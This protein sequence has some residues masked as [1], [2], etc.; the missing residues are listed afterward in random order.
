MGDEKAVSDAAAG[1]ALESWAALS[2]SPK[3]TERVLET[4][5]ME[6]RLCLRA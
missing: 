5:L 3:T 6:K 4:I 1:E 2:I